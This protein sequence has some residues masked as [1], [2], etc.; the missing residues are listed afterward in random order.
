[1]PDRGVV[2]YRRTEEGPGDGTDPEPSPQEKLLKYFPDAALA[3]YI[4]A[5]PLVRQAASGD[6]LKICLWG[7]LVLCVV[8]CY[9]YLDRFWTN[10]DGRQKAISITALVL[11]IAAIGGPF[12][13]TWTGYKTVW[14]SIV[15]LFF[16]AFMVFTKA[17]VKPEPA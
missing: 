17:P 6:A 11:Y 14:A 16:T 12:S 10:V 8:F 13:L 9:L 1:M 4:A 7:A 5:D 15:A 2:R 3:L